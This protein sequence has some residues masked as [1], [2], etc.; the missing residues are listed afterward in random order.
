MQN[1]DITR[2]TLLS[3][4][5]DYTRRGSDTL[6]VS[7]RGLRL[8]RCSYADLVSYAHQTALE[9]EAHGVHNG[10]AVILCGENSP[11]WVIA[12]WGCLICGVVVVPLDKDSSLDFVLSVRQQTGAKLAFISA[13]ASSVSRLDLPQI[14][15]DGLVDLISYHDPTSR[16]LSIPR[17]TPNT[18]AEVVFT[19]GTTSTPKGVMLTHANLLANLLPI[20]KEMSKYLKWE[21]FFHPIR[22]LNLVPLSHV[23]GQFMG[24]FVPQLLGAEVHFNDSLNPAEIVERVRKHRI[25]VIVLVPRVLESLRQWIER[26]YALRGKAERLKK[27][28]AAAFNQKALRRWWIFRRIHRLLGWKFWAFI[29]GGATLDAQT[30]EFWRRLGFAVLQGYGMTE[31]ASLISVTHPFKESSGSIGAVMPGYE[32]KLDEEGEIV[33]RGPS[34]SPGYWTANG[35][36]DRQTDAWLHTGDMGTIDASGHLH[37]KGRK[38]DVIV[39]S[40]GLNVYPEDLEALLNA[41]REVQSS[42]VIKWTGTHGDEPLAVLILK[43]QL[44]NVE[45]II[46]RANERLSEHQ[47]IRHWRVWD[48]PSFPLTSTQKILKREVAAGIAAVSNDRV[49]THHDNA[50]PNFITAEAAR[51]TGQ[52][53]S[54]GN[55]AALKL[56]TDLKLDSLGRVELLSALEDRFQIE[57][58]E[59]TFTAATTVGDVEKIVRGGIAKVVT[60]YPYPRWSHYF[61]VTWIRALLFYTIILPVTLV[62]S[63]MRVEGLENLG[64]V[65][66][67]VLFISNHVTLGDHALILAALPL[68]RRHRVAIAMEGERLREWLRPRVATGFF[69]R[70]QFIVEYILVATFFHVFP[71]PK[72]SGFRRSFAYAGESVERGFSVLVFPEGRRA[73]RGQ[74]H[75]SRFKSGIGLLAADLGVP[76]VPVNLNGLY[77]LKRRKQ[78][79]AAKDMVSVCFGAPVRFDR[80]WEPAAIVTELER[81]L[82]SLGKNA[83]ATHTS[84]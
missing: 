68:H 14:N 54:E 22:F 80:S 53:C 45:R 78:Y 26:R 24:M 84:G 17:I 75:M 36:V 35:Q 47:R 70:M 55:D 12:F 38:K 50:T 46:E 66:G 58:D 28:L 73:P 11:E 82:E 3:Y 59:A 19:S 57:I 64:S 21:R 33:V 61:P 27:Q 10:D 1:D 62:M 44:V 77:D 71:L 32:V 41:D 65:N 74:M 79:F 67:P 39:T 56:S 42:C 76:V 7:Q 40:A 83:A 63:R 51:I 49:S 60:P 8:V 34:V 52:D 18:L 5:P 15:L 69:R 4:L 20:E 81:R 23:F 25:S 6:F 72:K 2:E 13:T 37:F 43:D 29:C 48:G 30:E 9:L 31:T 16:S